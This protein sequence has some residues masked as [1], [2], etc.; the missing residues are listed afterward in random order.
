[1]LGKIIKELR[2][3]KGITQEE[4]GKII[5]VTT[6]MVGMY[7]TNAR[8]PSYEVLSKIAEYFNVSTDYLLGK[9]PFKNE[10]EAHY[11]INIAVVKY[12]QNNK[13]E[14]PYY[15]DIYSGISVLLDED[16]DVLTYAQSLLNKFENNK[17]L[18][19]LEMYELSQILFKEIKGKDY[20]GVIFLKNFY[21]DTFSI[22]INIDEIE[23]FDSTKIDLSNSTLF[24]YKKVNNESIFKYS[25]IFN[26]PKINKDDIAKQSHN[27]TTIAAHLPEGVQLT[28]EEQKQLNDYIE[29]LLSRRKK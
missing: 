19:N 27:I 9:T 20:T 1:M 6:S 26:T 2:K 5:G 8:K 15:F 28:E 24:Q 22:K 23:R 25:S 29:F 18:T 13:E 11:S 3:D 16:P 14:I 17:P 21:D 12:L 10:E 4:L 7:E